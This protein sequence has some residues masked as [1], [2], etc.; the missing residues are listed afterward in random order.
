MTA[1]P[2]PP[3]S[4]EVFFSY[5]HEDEPLRERLVKALAVLKRQGV[6]RDWHDRMITAG[7]E[8]GGEISD[9][10]NS[11][12]VIL[13]LVSP[14]FVASDYCYDVEMRRAMERHEAGEA[15]VIPVILR[16]TEGWQGANTPFGKL[17]TAPTDG[18]PVT[19]WG[20]M[21]EAFADVA[22]GIRNAVTRITTGA[23]T[24]LTPAP[25]PPAVTPTVT[26][27]RTTDR[28]TLV[29]TVSGLS[30]SDMAQLVMMVE[31]A[32]S[33]VS[34]HGTVPEQAAELIRWAESSTGPGLAAVE[35]ALA[36]FR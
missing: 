8:L 27:A 23:P 33:H 10:L 5:A 31:G 35:E 24:P 11:A 16:P 28:A 17:L 9:H 32:A 34:R 2:A 3:G 15:R 26:Q 13:L 4:T 20:D 7:T 36:N 21:D 18:R 25:L 12:Q 14:D 29:R 22:R 19:T 6:I 30:P 1:S